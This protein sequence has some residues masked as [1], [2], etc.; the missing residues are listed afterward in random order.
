MCNFYDITQMSEG[1]L[2]VQPVREYMTHGRSA[3]VAGNSC[4]SDTFV[5]RIFAKTTTEM[6]SDGLR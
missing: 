6:G 3:L 5:P 1:V 2:G 4:R